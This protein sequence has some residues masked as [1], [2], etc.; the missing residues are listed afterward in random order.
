MA[1]CV[2]ATTA[3]GCSFDDICDRGAK[4][5]A[6]DNL[7]DLTKSE[8]LSTATK[9]LVKHI[10]KCIRFI[11]I[12]QGRKVKQFYIGKTHVHKKKRGKFEHMT[13]STWRKSD[14]I[15]KRFRKHR[16][17]GYG[18][19][20]MVV[21]TLVTRAAIPRKIRNNKKTVIQELYA[22]AL[23]SRL[24]QY[25]LIKRDDKRIFNKSLD[26]GGKDGNKSIGYALYMAFKLEESEESET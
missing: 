24:I 10:K 7:F 22:L 15:S 16:E 23:E 18:R 12:G 6:C 25:F 2:S 21:L 5:Y 4:S 19:D 26:T 9:A 1:S 17:G 3:G 13:H 20:G 11:E 14:G 8:G